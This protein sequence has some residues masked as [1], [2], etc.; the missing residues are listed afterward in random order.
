MSILDDIVADYIGR[1]QGNEAAQRQWFADQSTLEDAVTVAALA[2]GPNGKRLSHQRRIPEAALQEGRR[3][4]L[5]CLPVLKEVR[6]FAGLHEL[7]ESQIVSINHIGELVIYDT[8]V[9]IGAW[10][11]LE[12]KVVFLHAGTRVG[13][14]R[15]GLDVSRGVLRPDELPAAFRC[16]RPREIEDLLCIYKENLGLESVNLPTRSCEGDRTT[17]PSIRRRSCP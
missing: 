6:S 8:A 13:A 2:V 1:Y 5:E 11:R 12:P 10:L 7:I 16:L 3:R 15:L 9:R 14:K 4:L 17:V